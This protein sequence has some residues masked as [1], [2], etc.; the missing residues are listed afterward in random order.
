MSSQFSVATPSDDALDVLARNATV[1]AAALAEWQATFPHTGL[2]TAAGTNQVGWLRIPDDD[3]IW[4]TERDPAAGPTSAHFEFL[5]RVRP[6]PMLF[7]YR[8]CGH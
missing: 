3:P 2:E 5:F 8:E 1:A 7:N 6:P 4:E